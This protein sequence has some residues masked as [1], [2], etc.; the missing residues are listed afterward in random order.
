MDRAAT[1]PGTWVRFLNPLRK[2]ITEFSQVWMSKTPRKPILL[3]VA[4]EDQ[5]ANE[6]QAQVNSQ[7]ELTRSNAIKEIDMLD[8]VD[9]LSAPEEGHVTAG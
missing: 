4:A 1:S 5:L 9:D 7:E 3:L 8:P 2:T 6:L